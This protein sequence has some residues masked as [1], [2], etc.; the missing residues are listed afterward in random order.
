MFKYINN[1]KK[2]KKDNFSSFL[3]LFLSLFSISFIIY[4][5]Y[6][7]SQNN[8]VE[9]DDAFLFLNNDIHF[10]SN[11]FVS[12][13]HG[14]YI[15]NFLMLFFGCIIPAFFN[16]HPVIWIQTGG[17]VIKGLF[18]ALFSFSHASMFYVRKKSILFLPI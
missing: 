3:F 10:F 6:L 18:F 5:V 11:F 15:P 17:A 12:V 9:H 1:F 4:F 14:K 16:I 13:Y 2:N 8:V 7:F